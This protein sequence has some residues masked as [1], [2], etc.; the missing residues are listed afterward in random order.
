[1]TGKGLQRYHVPSLVRALSI[2]ELLARHVDGLSMIQI[3]G[4]LGFPNNSVFR[5]TSTLFDHGYL[6]RDEKSKRFTLSRKFLALGYASISEK[7][8]VEMSID[9]MRQLRDMTKETALLATLVGESMVVLAQVP[10]LHPFKFMVD[11]GARLHLHTSAPGKALLA[12]LPESEQADIIGR[13]KL[14]KFNDR[15]LTVKSR[16]RKELKRVRACGYAVD[17]AE[18][19]EAVHCVGAPVLNQHGYP[20]ASIWITGPRD[21]I[22]ATSFDALGREVL[23]HA[24]RISERFGHNLL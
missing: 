20:I 22:P 14:V 7:N 21:R 24:R 19:L 10:G 11:P 2:L 18:Q 16:F 13:M 9:I 3:A 23:S 5:I 12:F 4:E 17:H 6:N 15:T 1:M 8:V